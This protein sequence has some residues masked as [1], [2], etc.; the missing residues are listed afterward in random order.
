MIDISK[1]C[2]T[3]IIITTH[4][5]EEARKADRVG[6]IRNGKILAEHSPEY[7]LQINNESSLENVFLKLCIKDQDQ[8][9]VIENNTSHGLA[10][11]TYEKA[12]N[13]TTITGK[14]LNKIHLND[15]NDESVLPEV[16]M[17]DET[18][19][20]EIVFFSRIIVYEFF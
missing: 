13:N 1:S 12:Q 10:N 14:T 15:D 9:H 6:L 3:T 8:T 19:K 5:I 18:N 11:P 20:R 2:R 17:Q 4:Y 7:L 16:S